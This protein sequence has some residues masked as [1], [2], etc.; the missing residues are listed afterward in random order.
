[1]LRRTGGHIILEP[2]V[3]LLL[4]LL[5]R[6]GLLHELFHVFGVMHTQKRPDRDR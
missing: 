1:M 6:G 5:L 3:L 4:L 2:L